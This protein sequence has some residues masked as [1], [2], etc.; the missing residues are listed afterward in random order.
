MPKWKDLKRYCENTGW[1]KYKSTDHDFYRKFETDGTMKRTKVSRSSKEI[2][3][4][5]WKRILKD[6]LKTDEEE[7][8]RNI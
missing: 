8:N 6:Q 5:L 3:K 7:F 2:P 4:N 1:E